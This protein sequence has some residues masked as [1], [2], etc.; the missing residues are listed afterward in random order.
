MDFWVVKEGK[1]ESSQLTKVT[2]VEHVKSLRRIHDGTT[3]LLQLPR[4]RV[5]PWG[6]EP[7]A[8]CALGGLC[9]SD[10]QVSHFSLW[11]G[12]ASV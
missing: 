7:G 10:W 11:R 3:L 9:V 12:V 6:R 2:G 5:E 8:G 1:Q 4:S